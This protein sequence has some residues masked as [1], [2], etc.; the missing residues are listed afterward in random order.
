MNG[1]SCMHA[2]KLRDWS[3]VE[4]QEILK[5]CVNNFFLRTWEFPKD[6]TGHIYIKKMEIKGIKLLKVKRWFIIC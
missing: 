3:Y 5:K 6:R 2:T 4:N 1:Q